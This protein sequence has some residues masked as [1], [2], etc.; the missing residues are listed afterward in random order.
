MQIRRLR[1]PGHA[2]RPDPTLAA[3]P[4]AQHHDQW[5]RQAVRAQLHRLPAIGLTP[6]LPAIGVTTQSAECLGMTQQNLAGQHPRGMDQ[7]GDTTEQ[8]DPERDDKQKQS[9]QGE[10]LGQEIRRQQLP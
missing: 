2:N 5:Q 7:A 10:R 8:T 3:Q 1:I 9:A 6:Q 4:K